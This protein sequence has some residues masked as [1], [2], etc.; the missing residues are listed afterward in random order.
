MAYKQITF[1]EQVLP[2][3]KLLFKF[4][5]SDVFYVVRPTEQDLFNAANEASSFNAARVKYGLIPS[6]IGESG[7]VEGSVTEASTPNEI[8]DDIRQRFANFKTVRGVQIS[9]VDKDVFELKPS[10]PTTITFAA[11]AVIFVV[12]L[13]FFL[14]LD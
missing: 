6:I 4:S 10:I 1:D 13:I 12:I 11:I 9:E 8:A 3:D 5:F 7:T 14:K 2:G